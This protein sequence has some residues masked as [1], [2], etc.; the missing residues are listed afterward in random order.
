MHREEMAFGIVTTPRSLTAASTLSTPPPQPVVKATTTPWTFSTIVQTTKAKAIAQPAKREKTASP[1][2]HQTSAAITKGAVLGA[3]TSDGVVTQSELQTAIEQASN[4]LRQLIYANAGTVGQG[5]Y[6]SGGYTNSIALTNRIDQLS[7]T[8][9]SN[10]T[11]NSVSGLTAADIPTNIVAVN[12]LPLAGGTL[13]GDLTLTGNLTAINA[14]TT[15][16]AALGKSYFAGNVGIGTTSP[17]ATLSVAGNGFFNSDLTASNITATGTLSVGGTTLVTTAGGNVGIGMTSPATALEVNGIARATIQDKGGQ[18]YN[19]KAYGMVCDGTTDDTNAFNTLLATIIPSGVGG[20]TIW[21]PGMCRINGAVLFPNDGL[22]HPKQGYIR[23]TGAGSSANGYWSALPT[24]PSGLDLRYAGGPKLDTRGAGVLE[25]DHVTLKDQGNDCTAFINTTNTTLKIHDVAFSGTAAGV[26]ACNDAIVAGGTG[27]TINGTAS[28]PFQG[29]GTTIQNNFFDKIR[30]GVYGRVYFNGVMIMNNTWSSSSGSNLTTA[31]TSCT[32]ANPTVCTVT[33]HGLSLGTVYSATFSGATGSWTPVNGSHALTPIDANTFSMPINATSFGALTGSVIFLSGSAIEFD[34]TGGGVSPGQNDTGNIIS[35][36]LV[37]MVTYPYFFKGS[38]SVRNY[39]TDNQLFDSGGATI[40]FYGLFN[41]SSFNEIKHGF[42]NDTSA[43]IASD[44]STNSTSYTTS[45]QSQTSVWAQPWRFQNSVTI[46]SS[47][48]LTGTG[49]GALTWSGAS[50][51]TGGMTANGGLSLAAGY[52]LITVGRSKLYSPGDGAW[53]LWNNAQ[54]GFNYL[55]FGGTSSSF[56]CL[57][58]S[59][60]TLKFQAG[61]GGADASMTAS[62]GTFSGNVGIGTTTPSQVLSVQGNG[63]FSG[64][65]WGANITATGTLSVGG[66]TLVTTAGGNVGIGTSTPYS[67]LTIWGIDTA[68]STAALTIANS[69]STTELQV[70]DNGNATLA[71]TLTQNSDQRLKMNIQPLN[72][73][74]TLALINAL[75]PVTFTWIDPDKGSN[76]QLGFIAQDVQKIFPQL[77][78]TTSPTALT[79][80]GTLGLNYLGLIAPIVEAVQQL[81][82]GLSSLTARVSSIESAIAGFANSFT[83]HQLNADELC[84]Q[85]TCITKSQL[86]ALLGS[87]PSVQIS[88]PTPVTISGT[89]TP[90]SINVAGNNPAHINVG[91]PYSDLG[92]IVTD[93]QGHDLSYRTF[94]NSVLSGNIL[95]DTSHVATDTI[96]YVATDTWGNTATATRTVIIE[97]ANDNETPNIQASTTTS[98]VSQ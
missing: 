7:G 98:A 6:S 17:F 73:S 88:A 38:A 94:I 78:S 72:A 36:N 39:F 54:T 32:N 55:C 96:D 47:V 24:S 21:L 85:G 48:G 60:T 74:S 87:Q 10:I 16:F 4:A 95:I 79:P 34:G 37:E 65:I 14:T 25:I 43:L 42:G 62:N 61:E 28:A 67:K 76:P 59:G 80:D 71:G 27:T 41:S 19:A 77:V 33:G 5:Q 9:L 81:S 69:A 31:V 49:N 92:A 23:I 46:A 52:P 70:F 12:Y 83:T 1:S 93:N 63:L 86:Q 20:G 57:T 3:S 68:A 64:N 66:T 29:Y 91:D 2:P 58:V 15:D 40:A 45:A 13:S 30:R 26:S 75:S 89:T 18:V 53:V 35:G 90:P 84:L 8:K 97:A 44:E 11:V 50:T 82:A 56:P 51:F 22:S